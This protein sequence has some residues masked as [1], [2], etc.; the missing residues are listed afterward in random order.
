VTVEFSLFYRMLSAPTAEGQIEEALRLGVTAFDIGLEALLA[1][2]ETFTGAYDEARFSISAIVVVL[3]DFAVG[4]ADMESTAERLREA[5]RLSKRLGYPSII[6]ADYFAPAPP[7]LLPRERRQAALAEI[8]GEILGDEADERLRF[9]PEPMASDRHSVFC[10][11]YGVADF[12]EKVAE[13][14]DP[15]RIRMLY[16]TFQIVWEGDDPLAVLRDF[17]DLIGH[18][19][20]QDAA[21][22]RPERANPVPGAGTIDFKPIVRALSQRKGFR[23]WV[24]EGQAGGDDEI[25]RSVEYVRGL[26][27]DSGK[28]S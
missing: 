23:F 17:S 5:A 7:G 14:V 3:N 26:L 6:P 27:G 8:L 20:L 28:D 12:A 11:P 9:V 18:I 25:A 21:P 24:V 1:E 4:R 22:G 13:K 10:K 16:D 15:T 2:E 19:H